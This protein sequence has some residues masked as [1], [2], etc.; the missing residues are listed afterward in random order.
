MSQVAMSG[1]DTITI[2]GRVLTA[3]ADQ[4][5]AELTFPTE[6]SQI[7][8]GKNGNSIYGINESGKQCELKLRIVRGTA[9]DAFL[10]NLLVSQQANFP[11]FVLISAQLVKNLGDGT[12]T[13]ITD[14]YVLGGGVFSKQVE[15]KSNVEGDTE[16]SVAIYTL[17]FSNAPRAIG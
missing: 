3:L 14:T 9:D 15:V 12:G 6:I 13:Q 10:N 2:N 5:V 17:K 11:G 8:T 4:N 16:Q 7:K 1:K